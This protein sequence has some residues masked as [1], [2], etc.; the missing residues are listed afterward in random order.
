MQMFLKDATVYMNGSLFKKDLF[1]DSGR[2]I[3][4]ADSLKDMAN[5]PH[6]YNMF[7]CPGFVDVHVHLREPGFIFKET[8]ETG[9]LA[10]ARG[11]YSTVC[12]MPNLNPPPDSTKNLNPQLE[13]IKQTAKINV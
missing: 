9:T 1:V 7:V 4:I 13:S 2:I 6:F 3:S 11:G 10:A 12:S 5:I 8:I